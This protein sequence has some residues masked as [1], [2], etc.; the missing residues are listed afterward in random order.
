MTDRTPAASPTWLVAL[1][2]P[3]ASGKSCLAVAAAPELSA[4]IVNCDSMQLVRGME[5]GTGKPTARQ[6][7]Q[8]PHHLYEVIDPDEGYSAG[9]YLKQARAVC[10][11]IAGRGCLPL[12]VGGTG[13]YLRALLEGLFDEPVQ[14]PRIRQQLRRLAAVEGP[15]YLHRFLAAQDPAAAARI[16]STD[17][18]RL[19]RALEV[20]LLSGQRLSKLQQQQVALKD[21]RTL[22][23]G[24]RLP[25]RELCDRI[26]R[27]VDRMFAAGLLAEV[28][29]LLSQGVPVDC[30]GFDA[31]GYR[32]AVSV[33]RGGMTVEEAIDQTSLQTRQYAK[34]QMTWFRK[35]KDIR[36]IEEAGET[37]AGLAAFLAL[38]RDNEVGTRVRRLG[39][40]HA[41]RAGKKRLERGN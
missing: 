29:G 5:V 11:R 3:T 20:V 27:R 4:E 9:L 30:R 16:Q 22:K 34:R 8:V 17:V 33:L 32:H 7:E 38:M 40:T 10:R 15:V 1:V 2:G 6:R 12:V 23:V 24:L 28:E 19:V 21:F 37:S 36:W 39:P 26:D 41:V 35:E 13:L 18:V 25:R 31:L 14:D